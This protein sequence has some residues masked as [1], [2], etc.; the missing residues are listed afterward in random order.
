MAAHGVFE[1]P[2]STGRDREP[3]GMKSNLEQLAPDWSD[4]NHTRLMAHGRG[5]GF[6]PREGRAA[7]GV[8]PG[9]I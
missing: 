6:I 4:L 5:P 7:C 8:F 3:L 9:W 1:E 2:P